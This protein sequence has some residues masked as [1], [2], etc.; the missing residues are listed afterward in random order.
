ML[1]PIALADSLH[2]S[3]RRIPTLELEIV[4]PVAHTDELAARRTLHLAPL[5]AAAKTSRKKRR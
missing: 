2:L 5:R 3:D 1:D 4:L